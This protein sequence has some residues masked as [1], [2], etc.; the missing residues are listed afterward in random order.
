MLCRHNGFSVLSQPSRSPCLQGFFLSFLLYMLPL[1]GTGSQEGSM[2]MVAP[3]ANQLY[4]WSEAFISVLM[5]WIVLIF[6]D[7]L[8]QPNE[9][10]WGWWWMGGGRKHETERENPGG[11]LCL[12]SP[13]AFSVLVEYCTFLWQAYLHSPHPRKSLKP[14]E[15]PAEEFLHAVGSVRALVLRT[16]S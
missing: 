16:S 6:H 12:Y 10:D 11:I 9:R 1:Q 7:E 5:L 2:G 8:L 14:N 3:L 15:V 13:G 4:T